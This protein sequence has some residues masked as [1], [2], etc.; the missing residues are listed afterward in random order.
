MHS[1]NAWKPLV[2]A[3]GIALALPAAAQSTREDDAPHFYGGGSV[4][5]NESQ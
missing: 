3:V 1:R 2:L 4:G 5:R